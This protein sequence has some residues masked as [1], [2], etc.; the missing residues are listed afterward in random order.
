MLFWSGVVNRDAPFWAQYKILVFI[1]EKGLNVLPFI[2]KFNTH[3]VVW[4]QDERSYQAYCG[5]V[6]QYILLSKFTCGFWAVS[7]YKTQAYLKK[8]SWQNNNDKATIDGRMGDILSVVI[9]IWII[10]NLLWQKLQFKKMQLDLNY[11]I[12]ILVTTEHCHMFCVAAHL[13]IV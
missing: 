2:A 10:S 5:T 7:Y 8:N 9:T 4:L 11:S 3:H 12:F 1:S 6:M 13:S